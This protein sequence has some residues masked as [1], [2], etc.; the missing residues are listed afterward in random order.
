MYFSLFPTTTFDNL[1]VLDITRKVKL[2]ALVNGSPLSYMNYTVQDGEKPEDVAYYY[3]DD[4]AYAWLVLASNDIVDPYTEWPK[5]DHDLNEMIKVKYASQ[6]NTTGE[7]VIEWTRNGT[8]GANIIHYQS[9]KDP[10][11]KLNRAS[12]YNSPS[13]EFFPVRVYDY[14]LELNE[15]RKEIVLVNKGLLPAIADKLSEI[16]N[17]A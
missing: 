8:I 9:L 17:N 6:A 7:A 13:T 4:P 3:Y 1:E 11:I 10:D 14:E 15:A 2:K 16:I 5:T 12:F